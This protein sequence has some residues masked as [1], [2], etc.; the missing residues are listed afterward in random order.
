MP[1]KCSMK[2]AAKSSRLSPSEKASFAGVESAGK[3]TSSTSVVR[4][5]MTRALKCALNLFDSCSLACD[6]KTVPLGRPRKRSRETPLSEDVPK[7][8]MAKGIFE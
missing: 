6:D 5:G 3:K 7:S 4:S 2:F 1:M 8:L